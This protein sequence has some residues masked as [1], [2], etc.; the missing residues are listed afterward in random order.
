[1]HSYLPFL[2][3]RIKINECSKPV[4]NLYDQNNYVVHIGSLKQAL[5]HGIIL[6]KVHKVMQFNQESWLKKYFDMKTKLITEAKNNVE[7]DFF[8]LMN[9]SAFGKTTENVRKHKDIKLV[10][11]NKKKKSISFRT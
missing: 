8:K 10:T 11:T 6:K 5:G 2:A 1:M 9:S 7:K 3:K 4:F